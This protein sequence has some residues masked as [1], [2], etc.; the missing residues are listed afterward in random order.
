MKVLR[1]CLEDL[2]KLDVENAD[3]LLKWMKSKLSYQGVP[4]EKLLTPEEVL[5]K[6]KAHCWEA[7]SFEYKEL[8]RI[9]FK[10]TIL[11]MENEECTATHAAVIYTDKEEKEY[12][13]FEWAWLNYR[14]IHQFKNK[15]AA[16]SDITSKFNKAFGLYKCTEGHTVIDDDN[17][18]SSYYRT[19]THW[20]N[21]ESS[22]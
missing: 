7:A 9:G 20:K 6:R 22:T 1:L 8:S 2:K 17:T 14:G 11:Y 19:M 21:V 5:Q 13:W 3:D 16:I 10:C 12:F 18:Q 4:K 15:E